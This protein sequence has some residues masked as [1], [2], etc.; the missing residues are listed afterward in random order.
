MNAL[1]N[2]NRLL[3]SAALFV[4]FACNDERNKFDA[5]GTFEAEET[6]IS[7]E[8]SG[9]LLQFDLE[10]GQALKKNQLVGYIDST[11][12]YL[13]KE[14]LHSQIK[15]ILSQRPD[16]ATQ[17]ASLEVQLHS[18]QRE[19]VRI[20]NLVKAGAATQKQLDDITT[21][22]DMIRRQLT[23]QRSSLGIT[24][25]SITQQAAPLEIQIQ[26]TEDLLN[27]CRIVNPFDGTVLT[28]YVEES[29]MVNP[30]KPL[31]KV[32]DLSHV[33]LRAYITGDQLPDIKLN[34][35]VT[36]LTD[37]GDKYTEREGTIT[38]ISDKAEFTP[39]TILTKKERANLVYAIKIQ[40]PNDG[41]LKLGMYGEVRF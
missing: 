27:K 16:I 12:L 21:Q 7:A 22:A 19:Q 15:S 30:G 11:Q 34:Q 39:K 17:V 9:T 5:S 23:A 36:V 32:A 26:Q 33:T 18:A 13:K 3:L 1:R 40:V 20:S 2:L 14:Q 25:E 29:E 4:A 24:T 8:A 41:S 28:K 6:I 10:E 37:A 38:W 35:K 31:Y